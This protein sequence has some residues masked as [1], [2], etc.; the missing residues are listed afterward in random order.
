MKM[1]RLTSLLTASI[2]LYLPVGLP[3]KRAS[4]VF[5]KEATCHGLVA[6][7]LHLGRQWLSL[8]QPAEKSQAML[9]TP[10]PRAQAAEL[11]SEACRR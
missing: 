2:L 5:A 11:A 3:S 7:K 4:W 6:S 9:G 1:R 10:V 8:T